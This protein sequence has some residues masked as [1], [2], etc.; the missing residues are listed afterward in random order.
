MAVHLRLARH[1]SIHRPFY[2]IVAAD[3][4]CRRDGKFIEKLGTYN[5]RV[6]PTE[7]RIDEE[8][9]RYWYGAGAQVSNV[10][11]SLLKAHKIKLERVVTK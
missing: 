7:I 3:H 1:G 9:V 5:P 2:H 8:R 6:T 4:R 11:A 10:V